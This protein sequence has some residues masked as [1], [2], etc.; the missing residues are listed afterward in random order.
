MERFLRVG[1]SACYLFTAWEDKQNLPW[2]TKLFSAYAFFAIYFLL[3]ETS[4]LT[5]L[6]ISCVERSKSKRLAKCGIFNVN[7]SRQ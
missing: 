7:Y 2:K 4:V 1:C 6:G 3:L 5:V